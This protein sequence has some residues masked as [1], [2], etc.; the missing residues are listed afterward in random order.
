MA[1]QSVIPAAGM[2][3][4]ERLWG[5]KRSLALLKPGTV[6]G[7]WLQV[8]LRRRPPW[9][10][11]T[12]DEGGRGEG[13]SRPARSGRATR[14]RHPPMLQASPSPRAGCLLSA[15]PPPGA[16]D[17]PVAAF[18]SAP[19]MAWQGGHV[20]PGPPAGRGRWGRGGRREKRG[21]SRRRRQEGEGRILRPW[22]AAAAGGAERSRPHRGAGLRRLRRRWRRKG[23][24]RGRASAAEARERGRARGW[25][26]ASA[27]EAATA[28]AAREAQAA[29]AAAAGA[30]VRAL[31]RSAGAGRRDGAAARAP[32]AWNPEPGLGGT[33]G[34][35]ARA[36]PSRLSLL[37]ASPSRPG[38]RSGSG[39]G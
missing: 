17:H 22:E 31:R 12:R 7:N 18:G 25:P 13:V 8:Q 2:G 6:P 9:A 28:I 3:A 38:F 1:S 26:L 39:P 10:T 19:Y 11:G 14:P 33:G 21:G 36:H 29:A 23:P 15:A 4:W 34:Y 5:A 37:P 27:G 16:R 20:R 30:R 32:G 24:Q 35:R